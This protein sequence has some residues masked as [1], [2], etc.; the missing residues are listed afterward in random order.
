[1]NADIKTQHGVVRGSIVNGVANFKGILQRHV[2]PTRQDALGP[3]LVTCSRPLSP[4]GRTVFRPF[5]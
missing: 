4:T 5:A 3:V 2:L 1:M